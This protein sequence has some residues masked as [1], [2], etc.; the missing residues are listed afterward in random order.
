MPEAPTHFY[1]LTFS[2]MGRTSYVNLLL[3]VK[4][5]SSLLFDRCDSL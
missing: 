4:V 3:D 5:I 1:E 2:S